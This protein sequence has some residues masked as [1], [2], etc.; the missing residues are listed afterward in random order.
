MV[1][2]RQRIA[3]EE[4]VRKIEQKKAE[5][6][7]AKRRAGYREEVGGGVRQQ[8]ADEDLIL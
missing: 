4:E 5:A 6:E 1:R 3:R 8:Q 7:A 2:E